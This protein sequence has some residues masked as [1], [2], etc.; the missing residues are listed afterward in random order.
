MPSFQSPPTSFVPAP[1]RYALANGNLRQSVPIYPGTVL[2]I[3]GGKYE[4]SLRQLTVEE[5][6]YPHN[7]SERSLP[8]G[9]FYTTKGLEIWRDIIQ[10]PEYQQTED[11]IRL[12]NK[13][14]E[15]I[16][17]FIVDGCT[18]VDMGSG[19]T[20]KVFPLLSFL[21]SLGVE[22]N[23]FALDLS[24]RALQKTMERLV[25]TFAYVKCFGLWG[26]FADGLEW[27]KTVHSPKFIMSLG[28][29]FGNDEF[30]L[31]V[32]RLREWKAVMGPNDYMLLGLD[33]CT[34]PAD[35]WASYHDNGMVWESFI[36]NGL[37][38]SNEVLG[39]VWY[40]EEDWEVSGRIDCNPDVLHRFSII[41][42]RDIR[43]PELGLYF[44]ANESVDFFE[45]WKYPPGRM[46]SQFK[47]AGFDLRA[48]W[49]APGGRP[50]YE[51]LLSNASVG[52]F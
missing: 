48:C 19:D 47:M 8:T 28:S 43:C 4:N 11:E 5:F 52:S 33:A 44:A 16:T 20:R 2:D 22:V 31:A 38:Y 50:F 3:G 29:M 10:L 42:K 27:L 23:Y 40:R 21:D 51:Y 24:N 6:L 12:L 35:L 41:A 32:S 30:K 18:I 37:E 9:L 36:R 26:S 34:H 25:P 17:N 14:K 49:Q 45:A 39:H 7:R 15:E 13:F 1:P 46:S